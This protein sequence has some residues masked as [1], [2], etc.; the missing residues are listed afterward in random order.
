M[1]LDAGKR[2]R[3]PDD[4][5]YMQVVS[6]KVEVYA[7]TRK[8]I[9]FRQIFMME[10][11]AGGAVFPPMDEFEQIDILIYALEDTELIAYPLADAEPLELRE[12]MR[13]W[14]S[15]LAELPWVRLIADRGDEILK[16]WK[17]GGVP[18]GDG[19][20]LEVLLERFEENESIFVMFAG[21]RFNA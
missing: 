17:N 20:S 4:N 11:E 5:T 18:L 10:L 8:N 6:G 3:V 16:Y 13:A 7:V 21:I 9:S 2:I 14:F 15:I 12:Q 19:S 1:R